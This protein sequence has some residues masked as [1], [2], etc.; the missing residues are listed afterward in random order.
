MLRGVRFVACNSAWFCKGEDD[1]GNLWVGLPLI[2]FIESEGGLKSG[3]T[4]TGDPTVCLIHHPP[5]WWHEAETNATPG[6]PNV[7]DYLAHRTDVI[8][9]G[10]THGE[11]RRVD[12][13]AQGA[14]HL[15]GGA[16][17][18]GSDHY[19]SYRLIRI[20]K[21]GLESWSFEYDPRSAEGAWR[22]HGVNPVPFVEGPPDASWVA[23]S[24][25]D[26]AADLGH[27]AA[28][29]RGPMEDVSTAIHG[30]APLERRKLTD[31][32]EKYLTQHGSCL[33][34]GE[35]GSGKSAIAKELGT[36]RYDRVVWLTAESLDAPDAERLRGN[37]GL[38][39]S[40]VD[41]L[42]SAL[43]TCL[44]VIDGAE[45]CSREALRQAARLISEVRGHANGMQ[46][47]FLVTFQLEAARRVVS[48]LHEGG[49]SKAA[50]ELVEVDAPPMTRWDSC[51][52]RLRVCHGRSSGL[53]SESSSPT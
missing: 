20:G 10:H 17:Y 11:V 29:S 46:M 18:S 24:E 45:R 2:R 16:G 22:D 38:K 41:V 14:L 28:L 40:L 25:N 32:I 49:L 23:Q 34:T 9:S 8:L 3:S 42:T 31:K 6:R 15:T 52:G 27:L 37:L 50:A 36:R 44:V 7:R 48:R 4:A 5:D 1:K 39:H 12:R 33:A 35:S 51:L 43:G 47:H 13:I 21:K 53:N 19:N 26:L 30:L